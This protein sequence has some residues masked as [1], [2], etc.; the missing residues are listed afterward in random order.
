VCGGRGS[1]ALVAC[2]SAH[3]GSEW[4]WRRYEETVRARHMYSLDN[5]Q[6]ARVFPNA[7]PLELGLV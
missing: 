3:G 6:I 5:T 7:V 1:F 4:R 2:P